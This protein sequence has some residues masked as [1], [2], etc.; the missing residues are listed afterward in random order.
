MPGVNLL[1]GRT[2]GVRRSAI[3]CAS[4]AFPL[5]SRGR[6]AGVPRRPGIS[7]YKLTRAEKQL[8]AQIAEVF[9]QVLP[10]SP[11]SILAPR[12][13][14]IGASRSTA[15]GA[16]LPAMAVLAQAMAQS[17]AARIEAMSYRGDALDLRLVAPSVEALD[18]IKQAV[19]QGGVNA[20]LQSATPRGEGIEGRLQVRLGKA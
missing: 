18:A 14:L 3:G 1:Q 6:G 9:A 10:A 16:L 19:T 20:E 11:S 17:P 12:W 4:G 13:R 15:G 8:D 2:A 5:R 7:L